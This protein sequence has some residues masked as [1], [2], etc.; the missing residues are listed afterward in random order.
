MCTDIS[1]EILRLLD[2][3]L[4]RIVFGKPVPSPLADGKATLQAS[5]PAGFTH[6]KRD[7]IKLVGAL[8]HKDRDIQDR[9]RKCGGIEV[10][11][12]HCVV[13]ERNPCA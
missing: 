3:F 8:G 10:V 9:V 11:L 12:N 4:P 1:A 7:L 5:D 6:V 13:D 2:L